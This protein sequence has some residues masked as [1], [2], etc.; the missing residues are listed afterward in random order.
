MDN[1]ALALSH[2]LLACAT[3]LIAAAQMTVH[4]SNGG[5]VEDGAFTEPMA[6]IDVD[7]KDIN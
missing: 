4:K 6:H 7:E 2:S 5:R 3:V 1:G